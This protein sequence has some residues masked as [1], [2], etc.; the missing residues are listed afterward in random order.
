M[1]LSISMNLNKIDIEKRLEKVQI[2]AKNSV[3]WKDR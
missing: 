2:I 1:S 3:I